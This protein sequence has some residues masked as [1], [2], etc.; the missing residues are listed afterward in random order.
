MIARG[1]FT[2][3][4]CG[5]LRESGWTSPWAKAFLA[6]VSAW[7]ALPGLFVD[8]LLVPVV[9]LIWLIDKLRKDA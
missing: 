4:Y 9:L 6:M 8:I 1:L 7:F 3:F 5:L 2:A